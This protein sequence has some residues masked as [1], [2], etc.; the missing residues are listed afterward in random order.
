VLSLVTCVQNGTPGKETYVPPVEDLQTRPDTRM[1]WIDYSTY[2]AEGT[3]LLYQKLRAL[4]EA[5]PWG[6]VSAANGVT[7]QAVAVADDIGVCRANP[8][9]TFTT[10]TGSRMASCS[11]TWS[12][13]VFTYV[14]VWYHFG[15]LCGRASR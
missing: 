12:V 10:S 1:D 2:D 3:W 13:G 15:D 6:S 14:L 7:L 11:L 9:S 8:C 4:L 5:R